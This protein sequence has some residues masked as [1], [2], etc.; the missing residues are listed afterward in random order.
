MSPSTKFKNLQHS[1]YQLQLSLKLRDS[2][3][4]DNEMKE[5]KLI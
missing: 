2:V 1:P 3:L 4:Y 5:I